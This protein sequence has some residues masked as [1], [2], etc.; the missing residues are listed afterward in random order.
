MVNEEVV[1]SGKVAVEEET[2]LMDDEIQSETSEQVLVENTWIE[3]IVRENEKSVEIT[4]VPAFYDIIELSCEAIQIR[5]T[6]L[7][8]KPKI[9][10]AAPVT[11]MAAPP[12]KRKLLQ[13]DMIDLEE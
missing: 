12:K 6:P 5:N 11:Q 13:T 10:K 4:V 9:I 7:E 2:I 8:E 1:E 3:E